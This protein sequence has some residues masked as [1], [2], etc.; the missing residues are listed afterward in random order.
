MS[1]R[2]RQNKTSQQI[3][4]EQINFLL[5]D[6]KKNLDEYKRALELK[7]KQ[8]SDTKKILISAKESYNKTVA[9]N[10]ELKTYTENIKQR[11]SQY[12]QW[13]QSQFLENQKNY[14]EERPQKK[15]KKVVY[16]EEP[17]S[18]PELEEEYSAEEIKEEPEIKKSRK[19]TEKRKNNIFGNINNDAKRHKR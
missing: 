15:Y 18:E 7:E 17:D 9:E 8:L 11:F 16:E 1:K 2:G 3:N 13:Q 12:Q 14:Y 10:K 5:E 19:K 4:E 6:V